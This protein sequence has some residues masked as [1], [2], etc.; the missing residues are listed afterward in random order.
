MQWLDQKLFADSLEVMVTLL[1]VG[2]MDDARADILAD[3]NISLSLVERLSQ[4]RS[5]LLSVCSLVQWSMR[6]MGNVSSLG[7]SY[8]FVQK[9]IVA[10]S[11]CQD[12]AYLLPWLRMTTSPK[13]KDLIMTTIVI[14]IRSVFTKCL[15]VDVKEAWP[16]GF[17][18]QEVYCFILPFILKWL[19]AALIASVL[20]SLFS[21]LRRQGDR[22]YSSIYAQIC[23]LFDE[24]LQCMRHHVSSSK[25]TFLI[26][27]RLI[28]RGR[29]S[30]RVSKVT[31]YAETDY[32]V[33]EN[34]QFWH[35]SHVFGFLGISAWMFQHHVA[36]LKALLCCD[37][38]PWLC[39]SYA[40]VWKASG[41]LMPI[42]AS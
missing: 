39:K 20:V 40:T 35:Y 33:V 15:N 3:G 27:V 18:T 4:V 21:R 17:H 34:D 12:S 38:A 31:R 8:I 23:A 6:C 37:W 2:V 9:S 24:W 42:L 19:V 28:G 16:S 1:V 10:T 11:L 22:S 29:V 30:G 13:V 14:I 7:D 26:L 32:R 25:Q 5:W 41:G 36:S